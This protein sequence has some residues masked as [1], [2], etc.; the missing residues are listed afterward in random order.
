[1]KTTV[2]QIG[3][4]QFCVGVTCDEDLKIIDGPPLVRKFIGQH[5]NRLRNWTKKNFTNYF[6]HIL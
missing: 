2:W 5:V 6:F 4:D 3:C 1:M